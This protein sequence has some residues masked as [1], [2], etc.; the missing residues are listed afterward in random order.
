MSLATVASLDEVAP[1]ES[2]V[3]IGVFDGVHRG[4]RAIIDR[5]VRQ[6]EQLGLRSAVVTFDRHPMEV[7]RPGSQPALLQTPRRRLSALAGT[8]VDLVATVNFDDE[9]RHLPP[10]AFVDRTLAPLAPRHVVV[11]D[12]F[13]F[14]HKAAGDVDTLRELGQARG[15]D[16]EA[17]SL[18]ELDGVVVS[19]TEIRQRLHAGDVETA[20][21]M[22]GRPH[23]VEGVVVR[24]DQR[25]HDLGFPTCNLAVDPRVAVP[26]I[27]I[28]AGV[29]H[30]PDGRAVDAAVSVGV[31]PTFGGEEQ[32]VEAH[33]LDFDEDLYG[34][35]LSVD[36]RRRLRGEE[37]FDSAEALAAQIDDDVA[38]ARRALSEMRSA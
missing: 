10:E 21:A 37:R 20:A 13:R 22:L 15:F 30:L 1:G 8:G 12:N 35:E 29:A 36:F 31:N 9:L 38:R 16:V 24:G 28:Y 18:L 7:I 3:S 14:G 5:A 11:G 23:T 34:A 27:G 2:V 26:A 17:V 32:R 33:L 19:S 6:A 25:G 4:H